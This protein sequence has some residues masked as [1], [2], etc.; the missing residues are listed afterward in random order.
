VADS[1][2]TVPCTLASLGFVRKFVRQQSLAAGLEKTQI[3]KLSLAIDEIAT[4]A[5]SHGYEES[6]TSGEL[7]LSA[8]IQATTLSIVLED[9]APP[10]DP[11]SEAEPDNLDQPLEEREAGGLGVYLAI[12]NVDEFAYR[13]VNGRN[14]YTF[15]MNRP[16]MAP[17]AAVDTA[18][19]AA[20]L[21]KVGLFS[22]LSAEVLDEIARLAK[23]EQ[24]STG[25]VIF[26]KGDPGAKLYAILS[27]AVR[28]HDEGQTLAYLGQG[29]I[30]G[31]MAAIDTHPRSASVTTDQETLLLSLEQ[32]QLLE[33]MRRQPEIS[34]GIMQALSRRFRGQVLD[35]HEMR[36]R[37][38]R[39]IL[40]LDEALASQAGVEELLE[41]IVVEAQQFCNADGG[42]LFLRDGKNHLCF[43]IL[44]IDSLNLALG[45]VGK[46]PADLAPLPLLDEEQKDDC[47]VATYAVN[48]GRSVHVADVY[49]AE[50][51]R[52]ADS[53]KFDEQNGYRTVSC[54]VVPLKDYA[55]QVI[56]ALQLVNAV[57]RQTGETIPFDPLHQLVIESLAS[58]ATIALT[59]RALT[60][61]QRT[62]VKLESDL[63]TARDIQAGF[64]P[65]QLPQPEG[66]QVAAR[67]RPAREVAG[68]FYDAFML[69]KQN[70]MW[71][72]MADVVDK[73]VPA[74][75]FMA[76]VRSLIRAFAQQYYSVNWAELLDGGESVRPARG[77][78]RRRIASAGT[79]A[80]KNALTLTNKYVLDNH[81]DLN[82]FATMFVGMFDPH[83]GRLDYINAG[84]NPPYIIA[85]DG[86]LQATL[87]PS[88]PAVGMVAGYEYEIE[89][90]RL[91]PGDTLFTYTDGVTEARGPDRSF[92]GIDR[93]EELLRRP[94]PTA[95]ALLD[96]IQEA[97][98]AFMAGG[99]QAD[100]VTMVAV[101]REK[102]P[103]DGRQSPLDQLL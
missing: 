51:S 73:G 71:I 46:P 50:Q 75:L 23:I 4:N 9:T 43:V 54:F 68:D 47:S 10:F 36:R 62:L 18:H 35:L 93:L 40:P 79:I 12:Q 29:E 89:N 8:E 74:A 78:D 27:G 5:I 58:Q 77:E 48:I 100:D 31:E 96:S 52:F 34:M 87:Q 69:K 39:M 90:A 86:K 20:I 67:F 30:F 14:C 16:T 55:G 6:E 61:D 7:A 3:Y 15:I 98:Y 56:G 17:T 13:Y 72:V 44:R 45:G 97:V 26:E 38:G 80:L 1:T 92:F 49:Q 103:P 2:L 21:A 82:M 24:V 28:V 42:A 81:L 94:Y 33:L 83:S 76:L 102:K 41:R 64:L 91:A 11:L 25:N 63:E 99:P 84:H 57:D 60:A 101:K 70:R 19:V 66:W 53:R 32:E 85:E 65:N 37:L 59:M 22:Q 95:G 88:G